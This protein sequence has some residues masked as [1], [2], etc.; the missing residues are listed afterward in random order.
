MKV[1][2]SSILT[3]HSD[4]IAKHIYSKVNSLDYFNRVDL[5]GLLDFSFAP[6]GFMLNSSF[7][8]DNDPHV[9]LNSLE[10]VDHSLHII[11][12]VT[13]ILLTDTFL[14]LVHETIQSY[15]ESLLT[16][17]YI[18][19]ETEFADLLKQ[20]QELSTSPWLE[21]LGKDSNQNSA[22]L[23]FA[24]ITYHY[25]TG[26]RDVSLFDDPRL[27]LQQGHFLQKSFTTRDFNTKTVTVGFITCNRNEDGSLSPWFT[28]AS[29]FRCFDCFDIDLFGN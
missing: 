19:E 4:M 21:S 26:V 1:R 13:D 8:P 17:E 7:T 9:D 24:V 15:I 29:G 22:V 11:I 10:L 27:A 25:K 12:P 20:H 3:K 18:L 28:N 23:S 6:N 5:I 16:H 14:D 2:W